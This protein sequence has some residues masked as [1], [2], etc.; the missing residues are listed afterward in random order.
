MPIV[1]PDTASSGPLI[2]IFVAALFK[3][4]F[5]AVRGSSTVIL[6]ASPDETAS[7]T[8][9]ASF[10]PTEKKALVSPSRVVDSATNSLT[11][12]TPSKMLLF[13]ASTASFA[14][15]RAAVNAASSAGAFSKSL[16]SAS[17]MVSVNSFARLAR[18]KLDVPLE[19]S[20]EI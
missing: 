18:S 19:S 6:D 10:V 16:T 1:M 20:K 12:V 11:V 3:P 2:S 9:S 15:V 4:I 5:F 8:C 14:A 7:A 13:T 17:A